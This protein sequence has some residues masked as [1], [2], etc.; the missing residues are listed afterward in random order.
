MRVFSGWMMGAYMASAS[1]LMVS[2][3]STADAPTEPATP[4]RTLPSIS[5]SPGSLR[6][7][8]APAPTDPDAPVTPVASTPAPVSVAA[9]GTEPVVYPGTWLGL[10]TKLSDCD[11]SEW[12]EPAS[13]GTAL[14]TRFEA[15]LAQAVQMGLPEEMLAQARMSPAKL[16]EIANESCPLI[17][18]AAAQFSAATHGPG[19]P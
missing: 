6:V 15:G 10:C 4:I 5:A 12:S 17:C 11:C 9:V 3:C 18:E 16:S 13:C 19:T 8:P 2:G 14:S 7:A 1:L